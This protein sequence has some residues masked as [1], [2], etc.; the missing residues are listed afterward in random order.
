MDVD[1]NTITAP[2]ASNITTSGNSHHFF[3]CRR[4]TKNSFSTCHISRSAAEITYFTP[5]TK[6]I[7]FALSTAVL[8]PPPGPLFRDYSLARRLA[9]RNISN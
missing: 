4:K 5:K 3:S 1:V 8:S 7:S 6:T 9:V 2:I